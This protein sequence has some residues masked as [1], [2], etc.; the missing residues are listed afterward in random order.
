MTNTILYSLKDLNKSYSQNNKKVQALKNVNLEIARGDLISIQGP[1]GGGK[2]TLLQ[3]L[4]GLDQPTS[5]TISL[6]DDHLE[7]LSESKLT[8]MRAR[9]IGFVFQNYNLIPTLTALE[10]VQ[11]ALVPQGLS[12]ADSEKR[13]MAAL[14]SVSL[15]DR[16]NHLP[17]ELSGGQQQRVAIARALVK[18]PEVILADEPTGNL[19]EETRDQ[20]IDLL[21]NLNQ[22]QGITV[23]LV[24]HDSSVAKRANKS[25]HI[26]SGFVTAKV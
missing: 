19:D 5:G 21:V 14:E 10:N 9:K 2:S 26:A 8:E 22:Q 1:T 11:T 16:A 25:L 3:M 23:I 13:A 12:K 15:A 7:K 17:A 4:G 20:I 6:A 24:T 18:N